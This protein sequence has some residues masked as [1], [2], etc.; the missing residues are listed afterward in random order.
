[1]DGLHHACN[2]HIAA[3]V[4]SFKSEAIAP[5]PSFNTLD[6]L[7]QTIDL[8]ITAYISKALLTNSPVVAELVDDLVADAVDYMQQGVEAGTI[9]PSDNPEGRASLLMVW[10]L[11]GL[12]LHS[13][14]ERLLGVD[15]TDR[16]AITS[17]S[18]AAYAMP[19]LELMSHGILA[20]EYAAQLKAAFEAGYAAA[21]DSKDAQ[22]EGES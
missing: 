10:V 16:N 6:A 2:E 4:R 9:R 14:L 13:H 18:A 12:V 1:M 5:S 15:I 11:G 22:P 20:D 19:A 21:Q 7:Q 8:P 17:P 3:L